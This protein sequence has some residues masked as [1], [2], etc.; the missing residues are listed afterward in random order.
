MLHL[1]AR[2]AGERIDDARDAGVACHRAPRWIELERHQARADHLRHQRSQQ[3]DDALADDQHVVAGLVL[4]RAERVQA[5]GRQ[6]R[7]RARLEV[8][9]RR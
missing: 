8:D 6:I 7:E 5:Q 4:R 2:V 3:S 1:R 9:V